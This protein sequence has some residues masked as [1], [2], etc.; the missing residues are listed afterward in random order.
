M[1]AFLERRA[2]VP[3][4]PCPPLKK[5]T[6][7]INGRPVNEPGASEHPTWVV[8]ED[9]EQRAIA[10]RAYVARRREIRAELTKR[11]AERHR[12]TDLPIEKVGR[13]FPSKFLGRCVACHVRFG[14][15]T[16][17][18]KADPLGYVHVDCFNIEV[19]PE[20]AP[21]MTPARQAVRDAVAASRYSSRESG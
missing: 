5:F 9:P 6:G 15:R 12:R 20:R 10:R 4:P 18:A 13:A 17:I 3:V 19:A 21:V 16:M 1:K 7:R 2:G 14:K 8:S 11:L